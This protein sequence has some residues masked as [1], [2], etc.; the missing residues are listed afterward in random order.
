MS[1][2]NKVFSKHNKKKENT[3][4]AL[5]IINKK[6]EKKVSTANVVPKSMKDKVQLAKTQSQVVYADKLDKLELVTTEERLAEFSK[7]VI[8]NGVISV[9]TETNGLDRIDGKVAGICLYT[10]GEKGIYIP[11]EHYSY[12]TNN[13]L[14]INMDR[15][16]IKEYLNKWTELGVKYILHNSKFD[17]HVIKH[18]IGA[19]I[20]PYW[21]TMIAGYLLNENEPHGL[22]LLY[23]KYIVG[24]DEDAKV[25]SFNSLFNGIEFNKIPPD[26]GYMY[27]G[28]DAIMTYELY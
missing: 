13:L 11:I 1:K 21:D 26:V 27:A 3:Q 14:N 16:I 6:K 7:M 2:M 23:Q 5:D 17:M 8:K 18:M 4:K 25:A 19:K 24:A 22:K 9:D 15:N 20:V 12:M 28:F 10:P